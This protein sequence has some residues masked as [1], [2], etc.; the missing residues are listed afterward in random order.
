MSPR[1]PRTETIGTGRA[2]EPT[3]REE[4][5]LGEPAGVTW[6]DVG[7]LLTLK[8]RNPG[9]HNEMRTDALAQ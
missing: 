7:E 5:V 8:A 2:G 1:P 9:C 4:R 3:E 6:V